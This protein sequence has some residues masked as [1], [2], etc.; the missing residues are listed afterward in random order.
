MLP[1]N[2]K[3]GIPD[4]ISGWCGGREGREIAVNDGASDMS[5]GFPNDPATTDEL[6]FVQNC[7]KYDEELT[8]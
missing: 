8:E 3:G 1:E 4:N 7:N 6:D 2:E 5:S